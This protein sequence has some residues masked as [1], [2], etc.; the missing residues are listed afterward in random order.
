[1][2]C[3]APKWEGPPEIA[4]AQYSFKQVED[5]TGLT[6]PKKTIAGCNISNKYIQELSEDCHG[7]VLTYS[8]L[9]M[10]YHQ[11][12]LLIQHGKLGNPSKI[13]ILMVSS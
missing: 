11:A 3:G 8:G 7:Q 1:V 13:E 12:T 2:P 6:T 9:A 4:Q 10:K 5:K